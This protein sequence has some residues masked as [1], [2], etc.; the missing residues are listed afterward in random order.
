MTRYALLFCLLATSAFA[1]KPTLVKGY[2]RK[3]GTYVQPYVRS[4]ADGTTAN[5]YG[6]TKKPKTNVPRGK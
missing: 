2:T 1:G 5:N 6:P 4:G 3:D